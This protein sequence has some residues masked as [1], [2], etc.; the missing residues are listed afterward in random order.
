LVGVNC[1]SIFKGN[2]EKTL[3]KRIREKKTIF[4]KK[5]II[6]INDYTPSVL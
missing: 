5:L 1:P 6:T 3:S 4:K 2:L